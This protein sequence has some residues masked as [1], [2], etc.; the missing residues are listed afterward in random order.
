MGRA[1]ARGAPC[2]QGPTKRAA[3]CLQAAT[4][5]GTRRGPP[6]K[7]TRCKRGT[8]RSERK[9]RPGPE[10]KGPKKTWDRSPSSMFRSQVQTIQIQTCEFSVASESELPGLRS[11]GLKT[12][13]ADI[14]RTSTNTVPHLLS[15]GIAQSFICE[16]ICAATKKQI[17]VWARGP[18]TKDRPQTDRADSRTEDR[19][20]RTARPTRNVKPRTH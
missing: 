10:D 17:D 12:N 14:A 2:K 16:L 1:P 13:P 4:G 5:Q 15:F 7:S 3:P 6:R 9:S 8:M 18:R 20:P 11:L 19:G